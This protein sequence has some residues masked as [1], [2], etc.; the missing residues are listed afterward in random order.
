[1]AE[2]AQF[3]ERVRGREAAMAA[4]HGDATAEQQKEAQER[5]TE[6]E[7]QWI[8][9]SKMRKDLHNKLQELVGN[10]RV[11][12]RIRPVV[13]GPEE[14]IPVSVEAQGSDLI[15]VVD[16]D[17]DR[18]RERRYEFTH[19]YG[20]G[21]A[22][23]DGFRDTEPLMTSVLDGFNVC[24][25]AYGQ[26]GAGK[27]FTMEGTEEKPGLVP[28]A[29]KRLFEVILERQANYR[30]E[31]FISMTEIYNENIRDLL[32]DPRADNSKKKYDIMRDPLVGMYVRDLTSEPIQTASHARSLILRGNTNRSTG[33]TN[34]NEQSSRSHMLVTL[35]VRTTDLHTNDN[36]VGK[37]SLVDLAGS[38]W[39]AKAQSDNRG[40]RCSRPHRMATSG[41]PPSYQARPRE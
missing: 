5:A 29:M 27:T 10:L 13:R 1:M 32:S 23:A 2:R 16:H 40:N 20:Q 28:R 19:V 31:C 34:L 26:S 35:T 11:Y 22:Q 18:D 30:H 36:Y 12:C 38:E 15:K 9:E 6:F 33:T 41:A 37:L 7:R 39:A 25:F 21:S 14:N 3:E 4:L 24:I 17:A 8:A